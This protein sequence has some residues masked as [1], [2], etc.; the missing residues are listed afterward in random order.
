[1]VV[2]NP[3]YVAETERRELEPEVRDWEPEGAL[4]AG[5]DG[6]DVLREVVAGAPEHL[7]PGGLLA[8][9]VGLGQAEAVAELVEATG[10]FGTPSVRPDLTGRPRMVLAEAREG[11]NRRENSDSERE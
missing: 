1:V 11:G 8:V 9:E 10:A 7:L 4:F 6:L 5:A 3:P 2:S